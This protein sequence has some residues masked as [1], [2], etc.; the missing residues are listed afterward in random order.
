MVSVT[1]WMSGASIASSTRESYH[2]AGQISTGRAR[3]AALPE[4][5]PA[6]LHGPEPAYG[7][8]QRVDA[9]DAHQPQGCR[10]KACQHVRRV[11]DAEVEAREADEEHHGGPERHHRPAR[12]AAQVVG[13]DQGERPVEADGDGGVAARERVAASRDR[14]ST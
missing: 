3:R 2:L 12:G 5:P 6:P 8:P 10:E 4:P 14:K 7:E 11:V 13:Q 1:K 9:P